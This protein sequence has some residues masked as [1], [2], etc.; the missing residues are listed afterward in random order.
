ME[1][2][3]CSKCKEE[4]ELV[5][6]NKRI[7]SKDGHRFE[8]K[9]CQRKNGREYFYAH[10]EQYKQQATAWKLKNPEKYKERTKYYNKKKHST[11]LGKIK[12]SLNTRIRD[13]LKLQGGVKEEKTYDLIGCSPEQL[14]EHIEKQF[15]EG[16][17][18]DNYGYYGWHLD[19]IIPC[20]SFNLLL[21]D[22]RRKCF[23]Y[24]N[25]QPL[26]MKDNIKK[27][28]RLDWQKD[29]IMG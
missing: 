17:T 21:E 6:F 1:T 7:N 29:S 14:R 5:H 19:H 13:M 27:G 22:E 28:D 10:R 20:V 25:L 15:T 4:K 12:H 16:M 11:P 23:R 18:W 26:W 3:I 9:L 2:K 8:C 24:T